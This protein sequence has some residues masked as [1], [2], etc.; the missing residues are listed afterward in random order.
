MRVRIEPGR[1]AGT[2]EAPPSKSMAHRLMICA[3]LA[4]GQ[5]VVRHVDVSEDMLATADCLKALGAGV[6][7]EGRDVIID[8]CRPENAESA[9][10][11]CRESGSTL[12][13]MIPLCL[14]GR[15]EMELEGSERLM[16]RPLDVYEEICRE[17]GLLFKRGGCRLKVRGPLDAGECTVPGDI[18]SQF[19]TG[20]MMALPLKKADSRIRI[21]P[22]VES[23]PYLDMTQEAMAAFGVKTEWESENVL[24]IPG[25]GAYRPREITVEGDWSNAAFFEALDKT[26][27]DVKLTGLRDDSLQ[28]DRVC[29]DCLDRIRGGWAEL[30]VADCPDLAPVLMAAAA[31]CHGAKLTGT[32][33]LKIKESDRG[34]AMAEEMAKFGLRIENRENEIVVPGTGIR[35]PEE[36]LQSHNDHRIAMALSVMC[37]KTGGTI[38]GAEAVRKSLPDYWERLRQLG[39]RAAETD[40]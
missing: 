32:R 37:V 14:A 24:R 31:L 38:D 20:L 5:S 16:S 25:N 10:L 11:P 30:D 26:G 8:G 33:R 21:L 4:E 17:R 23:R 35:P 40:A 9:T 3:A 39:I 34:A 36:I 7:R 1:P 13:F 2:Q 18:S 22:P 6:K 15:A 19:I 28:G 27:G 12:R 29:R